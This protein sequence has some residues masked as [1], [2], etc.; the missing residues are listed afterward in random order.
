MIHGFTSPREC[1][2]WENALVADATFVQDEEKKVTDAWQLGGRL[3]AIRCD[4]KSPELFIF[5]Q[6]TSILITIH[7]HLEPSKTL[8]T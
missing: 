7:N 2:E 3:E 1:L 8:G 4:A 6:P 5:L